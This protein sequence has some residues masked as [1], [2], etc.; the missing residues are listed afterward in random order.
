MA[1]LSSLP[2]IVGIS[3]TSLEQLLP[4]CKLAE[5][6]RAVRPDIKLIMGGSCASLFMTSLYEE[7]RDIYKFFDYVIVGEG[8][9]AIVQL[10]EHLSAGMHKLCDIPN[11]AYLDDQGDVKYTATLLENVSTL[12]MP[13]YS[14]LDLN[15]YVAPEVI[16][17]YQASRGC[18]YGFCAF[19]NHH[20]NYRHNYR[21]KAP[22][23]IIEDLQ[24]L[25]NLHG[26][27]HFQFVDEAIRPD[28]FSS[29]VE[30]MNLCKDL[31]EIYWIFYSRVSAE[32]T[33]D[34]LQKAYINGCR[35]V[36]FGVETFNQRLLNFIKKGINADV[37]KRCLKLFHECGIKTFAWMLCNLPSERVDEVREDIEEAKRNAENVDAYSVGMFGLERNTDMYK[38]PEQYNIVAINDEQPISFDSHYNGVIIDK[39]EMVNCF[40]NEYLPFIEEYYFTPNR[41]YVYFQCGK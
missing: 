4:A 7:K 14:D 32:Y 33:H 2:P 40:F 37:A 41:Y 10:Y 38:T 24:K 17:P 36:M 13:D 12:P 18:H 22:S 6:F 3:V 15:R 27:K 39:A 9:T 28:H 34:I 8:E 31:N 20:E 21:M 5:I 35:M 29:I 11:M 30:E 19:C 26:V 25:S 23:K 1:K 16:L